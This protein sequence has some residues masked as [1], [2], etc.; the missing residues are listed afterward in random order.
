MAVTRT[1]EDII[2]A[3]RQQD[4]A[5]SQ[6]DHDDGVKP[7]APS[8]SAIAVNALT[9]LRRWLEMQADVENGYSLVA[10]I[11]ELYGRSKS[12]KHASIKNY[13]SLSGKWKLE[14]YM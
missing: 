6:D 7:T 14:A 13:F 8:T 3:V 10:Q 11:E 9:V 2:A 5:A 4:D 12:M 1:D